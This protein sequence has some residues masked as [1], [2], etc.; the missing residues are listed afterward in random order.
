[1]KTEFN[2]YEDV[3]AKI[4]SRTSKKFSLSKCGRRHTWTAGGGAGGVMRF[5]SGLDGGPER[6]AAAAPSIGSQAPTAGSM[7]GAP[8]MT[9]CNI[10]M[11]KTKNEGKGIPLNKCTSVQLLIIGFI[12]NW[13]N[14]N[15]FQGSRKTLSNITMKPNT[16]FFC[17]SA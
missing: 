8:E 12:I 7:A 16:N 17:H 2:T 13:K 11:M 3:Q 6:P 5:I 10:W 9:Q 14:C 4:F 15:R 1:M